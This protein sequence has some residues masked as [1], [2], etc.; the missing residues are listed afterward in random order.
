MLY[1]HF[2]QLSCQQSSL[3]PPPP[4]TTVLLLW[5]VKSDYKSFPRGVAWFNMYCWFC[6]YAGGRLTMHVMC[7]MPLCRVACTR[8]LKTK[9]R[10]MDVPSAFEVDFNND[11]SK[12]RDLEGIKLHN[13]SCVNGSQFLTLC[14]MCLS[15]KSNSRLDWPQ[16]HKIKSYWVYLTMCAW[17]ILEKSCCEFNFCKSGCIS[18]IVSVFSI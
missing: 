8:S 7:H 5:R 16:I 9:G 11:F 4:P 12:A 1:F 2:L 13:Y 3:P 14:K 17:Y 10:E 6:K 18:D 15:E